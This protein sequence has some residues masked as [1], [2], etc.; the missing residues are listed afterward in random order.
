M[1]E[2]TKKNIKE[3]NYKCKG[4]CSVIIDEDSTFL[5]SL[6]DVFITDYSAAIFGALFLKKPSFN[7]N[8]NFNERLKK[9]IYMPF[10]DE[11]ISTFVESVDKL[12]IEIIQKLNSKKIDDN[13]EQGFKKYFKYNDGYATDRI[14]KKL[15]L[16]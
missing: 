12:K 11:G 5:I 3:I 16:N 10:A 7:I 9:N 2:L 6:S 1:I 14:I 4:K 13:I 8:F 15:E